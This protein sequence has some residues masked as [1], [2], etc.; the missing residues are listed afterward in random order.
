MTNFLRSNCNPSCDTPRCF[1]T[2]A[3][4]IVWFRHGVRSREPS[5]I[6]DDCTADYKAQM[7]AQRRCEATRWQA[8]VFTPFSTVPRGALGEE[9]ADG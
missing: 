5:V 3:E 7:Q 6:C 1:D 8:L 4:F 9:K 2:R